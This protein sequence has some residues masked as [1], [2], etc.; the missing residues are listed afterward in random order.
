M[1]KLKDFFYLQRNDRQAILVLLGIIIICLTLIIIVG[2]VNTKES[3]LEN[4]YS[5][6]NNPKSMTGDNHQES[7]TADKNIS[8]KHPLYYK[9][10]G[11][12][13]ELFP[14]DPNT[15][16]STQLLKL[17]PGIIALLSGVLNLVTEVIGLLF[18]IVEL[19]GGSVQGIIVLL[20]LPLHVIEG[21]FR[22]VKLNLPC[23]GT[24]VILAKGSGSVLQRFFQRFNFLLLGFD[25]FI[26]DRIPCGQ[27]LHG[28][29][30]FIKLGGDQLHFGA[31]DFEGL[32]NFRQRLLEL[33][34][35]L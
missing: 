16:D 21:G 22:V 9:V 12:V 33:F 27:S 24:A 23:L 14:F 5:A 18:R 34:F 32:V 28:L 26:Q 30:I 13:H 17:A 15:A 8:E 25:F 1:L 19:S 10:E 6:D 2:K 20:K 29:V 3:S 35:A 7:S 4:D 31:E 11:T